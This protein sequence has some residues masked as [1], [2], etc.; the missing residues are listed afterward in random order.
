MFDTFGKRVSGL[1]RYNSLLEE[2]TLDKVF[3]V[4]KNVRIFTKF[5]DDNAES[6]G[7][8]SNEFL[9]SSVV[10]Y[11][12]NCRIDFTRAMELAD[13]STKNIIW[14]HIIVIASHIRPACVPKKTK[15]ALVSKTVSNDKMSDDLDL[16]DTMEGNMLKG[17]VSSVASVLDNDD[18]P[19]NPMEAFS[20]LVST[21]FVQNLAGQFQE[22]SASGEIDLNNLLMAFG[23]M[24]SSSGITGKS[25]E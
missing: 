20:K 21:G 9:S 23:S 10:S 16:P 5:I 1:S 17:I 6:I 2:T 22:E 14:D 7:S 24:M 18:S 13:E 19:T 15:D 12:P 3:A 8:G 25:S 4:K 11:S